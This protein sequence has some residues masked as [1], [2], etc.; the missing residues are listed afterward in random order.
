MRFRRSRRADHAARQRLALIRGYDFAGGKNN[1]AS[2]AQ[3]LDAALTRRGCRL[4]LDHAPQPVMLR[5]TSAIEQ[6]T[7]IGAAA[8]PWYDDSGG[9]QGAM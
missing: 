2:L 3:A 6:T 9:A 5:T 8:S 1:S 7:L 4:D